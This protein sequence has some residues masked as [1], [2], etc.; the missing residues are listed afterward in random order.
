MLAP[1]GYLFLSI[2]TSNTFPLS[3][4]AASD[5]K[6]W[7]NTA[8]AGTC[9][10]SRIDSLSRR[11]AG[12]SFPFTLARTSAT[13]RI[14]FRLSLI[15]LLDRVSICEDDTRWLELRGSSLPRL[16]LKLRMFLT[17]FSVVGLCSSLCQIILA[18]VIRVT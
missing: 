10:A 3:P 11:N 12:R 17:D 8:L 16:G 6:D 15:S 4:G 13:F 5:L 14:F 18:P 1:L 7:T 2:S 9:L